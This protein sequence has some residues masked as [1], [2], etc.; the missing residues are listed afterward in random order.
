[1]ILEAEP[2]K[3]SQEIMPY[4]YPKEARY[5]LAILQGADHLFHISGSLRR[6]RPVQKEMPGRRHNRESQERPHHR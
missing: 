5:F 6:L 4:R 1:M 2:C 3:E